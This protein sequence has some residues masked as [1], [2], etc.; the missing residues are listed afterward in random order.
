MRTLIL[1]LFIALNWQCSPKATV[2]A[3]QDQEPWNCARVITATLHHI[4][5]DGC[6]W[7]IDTPDNL[8]F[9]PLN[10]TDFI[11]Q[12]Q[13]DPQRVFQIEFD[14]EEEP[15]ASICMSGPTVRIMCLKVLQ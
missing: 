13:L 2:T 9:E 8:R 4:E 7:V 10:L 6:T 1:S 5:L 11:A 14:Y 12:E 3:P 15:A